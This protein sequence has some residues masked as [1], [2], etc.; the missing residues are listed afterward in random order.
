M[1]KSSPI[2]YI[3]GPTAAGKTS[4]AEH[5]ATLIPAEIINMDIGQL[6]RPLSIGTAKPVLASYT[7]PHHLFDIFDTPQSL[8]VVAYAHM[9]Q[10]IIPH[11][12]E[13]GNYAMVVGGSA[14][15]L[16]SLFFPLQRQSM[17]TSA[18]RATEDDA[19]ASTLWD[20]LN[21]IDPERA[22]AIAPADVYRLKRALA[23]WHATGKPPSL[24]KPHFA[25]LFA[26]T[27]II[28]V[29]RDRDDLYQ[30][31]NS[32]IQSMLQAGWLDE[33]ERIKGTEWEL[34]VREKNI[35]GYPELLDYVHGI[36]RRPLQEIV[37]VISQKTR[38]YAKR[39]II[40]FRRLQRLL[41][42]EQYPGSTVLNLTHDDPQRYNENLM[43]H[44]LG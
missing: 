22:R 43:K 40:F 42:Q 44:I 37:A 36:D 4:Y 9:L 19:M 34:F 41:A 13:R 5:L 16:T 35:I 10:A 38:Q 18:H 39:Q 8:T 27:H 26:N 11:V 28:L 29:T 31:I 15:Y 14:F 12:H 21:M 7:V 17:E 33:I 32:R 23:L 25:P 1:G 20:Q 30:R 6:Y 24:Y 3:V 2:L